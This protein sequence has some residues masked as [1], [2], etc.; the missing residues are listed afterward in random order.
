MKNSGPIKIL[1]STV[2]V[3]LF[4]SYLFSQVNGW[5]VKYIEYDAGSGNIGSFRQLETGGWVEKN[6][7]LQFNFKETQRDEWSVYLF[8][9]ARNFSV[10]LDLHQ[11]SISVNWD[12]PN[13][14]KI[15]TITKFSE[16]NNL[17]YFF[18]IFAS[19]PQPF[20]IPLA[21]GKEVS[22]TGYTSSDSSEII[23][24]LSKEYMSNHSA[25]MNAFT[26]DN[27]G[28]GKVKG[29]II[30]GDLTEYGYTDELNA[31]IENYDNKITTTIYPGL[32]NHDISNNFRNGSEGCSD[33]HCFNRMIVYYYNKI[34]KLK[35]V[36]F[37]AIDGGVTY[38][39]GEAKRSYDGSF[40]YS[41]DEG[42]VHFVQLNNY[43]NYKQSSSF[44]YPGGWEMLDAGTRYNVE[45]KSAIDWLKRDCAI[46]RN[47]GQ[48]IILN[49]H[50]WDDSFTDKNEFNQILSEYK[51]SAVFTGHIHKS[52]GKI[53]SQ[54]IGN[55]NYMPVFR[56]GAAFFNDYLV[57]KFYTDSME[58]YKVSS[59]NGSHSEELVG[60][61][62]LYHPK[63]STPLALPNKAGQLSFYNATG[64]ICSWTVEY[65]AT[66]LP[67]AKIESGDKAAGAGWQQPIPVNATNIRVI[68]NY[69]GA[70]K[71]ETALLETYPA[72]ITRCFK[73]TYSGINLVV[74]NDCAEKDES[75]T[76][77]TVTIK[78]ADETGAGTDSNID[79][80][81]GG[82]WGQTASTRLNT[83]IS[84]NAFETGDSDVFTFVAKNVG[85]INSVK[86]T[87]DGLYAGSSWKMQSITIKNEKTG[88]TYTKTYNNWI[89]GNFY[90]INF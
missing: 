14:S 61:Y 75:N 26:N 34:A 65:D 36:T 30:N 9:V 51:V 86:I 54:N 40:A 47:R 7:N 62:P 72:P 44:F 49:F 33:N 82:S 78:T 69:Y 38:G 87:S 43:P 45:W 28:T 48:A 59:V 76:T 55:G 71:W 24:K 50:D 5:S 68:M 74:V 8:D 10:Q 39:S 46:A 73:F 4:N 81:I 25:S 84:G 13:K 37:D 22:K 32:G 1:L 52:C 19:D 17:D 35:N 77:Y 11:K 83:L 20:R 58:V 64:L 21:N 15:Y 89:E 3:L 31:Y 79:L 6:Q 66:G 57:G 63:P 70:F 41:W 16:E 88:K 18:M 23:M 53:A 2:I 42:N 80:V 85:E 27:G 60:K 12:K 90:Y 56:S 29:V 67:H